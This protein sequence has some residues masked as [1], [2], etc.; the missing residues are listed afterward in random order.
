M[1]RIFFIVILAFALCAGARAQSNTLYADTTSVGTT[2]DSI[3]FV[4]PVY[5]ML[6]SN[7]E[8]SGSAILW[9][10]WRND[11]TA[12]HRFPIRQGQV[13]SLPVSAAGWARFWSSAGTIHFSYLAY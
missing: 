13:L 11:T 8:T 10:A 1:K 7:D 6:V 4:T 9:Y 12:G 3:G 5:H 2:K